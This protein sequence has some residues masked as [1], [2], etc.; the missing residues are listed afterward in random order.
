MRCAVPLLCDLAALM[1]APGSAN[2]CEW[3]DVP[4][5]L[6]DDLHG[7]LR[8]AQESWSCEFV[9]VVGLRVFHT[10]PVLEASVVVLQQAWLSLPGRICVRLCPWCQKARALHLQLDIALAQT[11]AFLEV[12]PTKRCKCPKKNTYSKKGAQKTR[13]S[14]WKFA[15]GL[16][17]HV[18]NGTK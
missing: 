16:Q 6:L 15:P 14:Q 3:W 12:V 7:M 8:R 4:G 17:S 13:D 5:V 2:L 10:W 1:R 9:S 11:T 18:K